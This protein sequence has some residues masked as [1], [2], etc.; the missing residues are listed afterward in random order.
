MTDHIFSQFKRVPP[1]LETFKTGSVTKIT[2]E[3]AEA[4]FEKAP[5]H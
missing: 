1:V 2:V 3:T 5:Q 4:L